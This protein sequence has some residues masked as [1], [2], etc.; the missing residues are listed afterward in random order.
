MLSSTPLADFPALTVPTKA[1]G[2]H[3]P[4]HRVGQSFVFPF[5]LCSS[6]YC[7]QCLSSDPFPT[8]QAEPCFPKYEP[9]KKPKFSGTCCS[10]PL[11]LPSPQGGTHPA[12]RRLQ[13]LEPEAIA[14]Y[15][16][17]FLAGMPPLWLIP[18]HAS[19]SARLS[20]ADSLSHPTSS[21]QSLVSVFPQLPVTTRS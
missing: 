11:P 7:F 3:V 10:S 2:F 20:P 12:R 17:L 4:L 14:L 8:L 6:F 13:F 15:L 19:I 18:V 5:V 1:C 9:L 16:L 21:G